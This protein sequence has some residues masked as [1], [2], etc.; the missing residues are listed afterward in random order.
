MQSC[1]ML[2]EPA[3]G[4]RLVTVDRILEFIKGLVKQGKTVF[5]VEQ[6]METVIGISDWVIVMTFGETISSRRLGEI[7]DDQEVIRIYLGL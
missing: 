5:V 6:N 2:E 3:S 1:L 7:Q 4:L